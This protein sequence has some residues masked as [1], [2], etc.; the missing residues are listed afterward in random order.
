MAGSLAVCSIETCQRRRADPPTAEATVP[1]TDDGLFRGDGAFEVIRLYDG[2]AVRAGRPSRPARALRGRDLPRV[3]PRRV[4][5]EIEA[6]LAEL[7]DA[8]GQLRLVVTRGGRRIAMIEPIPA[9]AETVSV[10]TVT[11]WPTVVLTGVKTLS[12]AANM[13][14]TRIAKGQG[15]DEALLVLPDG[16]VLEAPTS[17]IFWVS[18][19]ATCARRRSTPAYSIRSPATAWSR[20]S[21][22][23]RAP[24]RSADLRAASEVFL[25]ST[26]REVQAVSA[27]RRQRAARG[28]RPAHPRSPGGIR[29]DPGQE[30]QCIRPRKQGVR[31]T[32]S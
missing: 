10:A 23:R 18:P 30:L 22:S 5:G 31:W 28:A 3:R 11:Y 20:R 13:Q 21:T 2:H 8:D 29:R 6:L 27:D 26:M 25:A 1:L 17:T 7:G 19:R 14:A 15:A 12:Y 16:I 4:R 24:G 32:S 9:H